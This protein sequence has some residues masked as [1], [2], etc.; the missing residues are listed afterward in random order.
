[1]Q[2]TGATDEVRQALLRAA[3][4]ELWRRGRLRW[5][6]HESQREVY[7]AMMA[8]DAARY[9]LEIA[10]RWGKTYLLVLIAI[11]V[12]IQHPG[13]RVVYGAPTLKH[14][15][16]FVHPAFEAICEDAPAEC[17]PKFNSQSGHYEFPE[18]GP[19]RGA[20]IHLFGAD[21]KQKANRGRGAEAMVAIFDE[22]GFTPFL[23]Y[24]LRSIFRPQLLRPGQAQGGRT[25]IGSTPAEEPEHDFTAI[26][27]R[28]E[29]N[30]NYARRTIYDNP[31]LTPVRIQRFIE[32]D[33]KE[34]GLA[35]ADYLKTDDFR[36]EY[37]AERV[38]NK[39][40][41][42]V[43]EWEEARKTL[44]QPIPRPQ[45]FRAQVV[46]DF[47]GADPHGVAFA[48]WHPRAGRKGDGAYVTEDELL[49]REG[50]NSLQI[51][52]A[53][54]AKESVLYG[55]KKWEGTLA[56]AREGK[57]QQLLDNLPE[58]MERVLY[59]DAP[60]QPWSRIADNNL[61]LVRDLF[62]LHGLAF[63]PTNKDQKQL[64]VNA[65]RVLI[66]EGAFVITPNCVHTDRHLK[67]TTW[68]DHKR[69]EYARKGGE[70][71]DLLDCAVYG[72]R[73][74][75]RRDPTPLEALVAPFD[76]VGG[77]RR[78]IEQEK[79]RRELAEVFLGGTRLGRK[80]MGGGKS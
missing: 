19:A 50:E 76:A 23:S 54:K 48:Y 33:A 32:E 72:V 73:N 1:M 11:E 58:W 47:G 53:V 5:K 24:I 55:A 12:C 31:R 62:D 21:T 17:R 65:L 20:Y 13:S 56:V 39:L 29:A 15:E 14:L 49:M 70:H 34:E 63:I 18:N 37:M 71:G 44:I 36:R 2:P 27:E 59:E 25:F 60:E 77:E 43:P 46:L 10:R 52:E 68:K 28:A 6:L 64:Q 35:P 4:D 78:R 30:G 22:A 42:A 38:V 51:A 79:Q 69:K 8:S 61:T 9:V 45:F 67:Q 40:L 7:D 16:E 57:L 26:A 66:R 41:V 3:R 80:L 74:L 75:D